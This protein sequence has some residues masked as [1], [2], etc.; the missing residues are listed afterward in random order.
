MMLAAQPHH[1]IRRLVIN[2]IGPLI[3]GTALR[4]LG[5]YLN[6]PPPHFPDLDAAEDYLRTTLAPF[7]TLTDAQWHHLTEHSVHPDGEGG[8]Y[9]LHHD[10]G[11]AEAYR[12]WRLGS[13]AMW[14]LWDRVRC[15]TLLLRGTLSDMLLTSTAEEMTRRGPKAEL[16][17][18][19]DVGHLPPLMTPG[20][21]EPIARFLRTP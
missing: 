15:P 2:D 17:E 6:A 21:I 7:G 5:V 19:P 8:G 1:P 20:Q 4:R 16:I 9:R 13:I 11:I 3:P 12:P 18:F 14:E 10:P